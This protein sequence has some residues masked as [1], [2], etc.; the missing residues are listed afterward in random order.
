[1]KCIPP[2]CTL[3]ATKNKLAK[4]QW[5][6]RTAPTGITQRRRIVN[7]NLINKVP[8]LT[9]FRISLNSKDKKNG[10]TGSTF[11][12]VRQDHSHEPRNIVADC[13]G[14]EVVREISILHK[15]T[16]C[17]LSVAH[18][19]HTHAVGCMQIWEI[20]QMICIFILFYEILLTSK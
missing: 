12:S 7:E 13:D 19:A 8:S 4:L 17:L 1:M 20:C 9:S 3:V 6:D 5:T 15:I 11:W 16:Y 10:K 18:I 14:F 2:H